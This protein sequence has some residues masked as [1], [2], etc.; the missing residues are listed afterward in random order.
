MG[1]VVRAEVNELQDVLEADAAARRAAQE[2]IA[3]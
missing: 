3:Q 1:R 2:W